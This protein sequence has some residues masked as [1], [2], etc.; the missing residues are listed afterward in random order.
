VQKYKYQLIFLFLKALMKNPKAI[1]AILPSSKRLADRI[2]SYVE[3]SSL[4]KVVELGAG[5]GVV[6]Q[7]M[8][9][10]GVPEENI[11]A[12]E[13]DQNLAEK[14][15]ERFPAIQIINADAGN[16]DI[17]LKD[18]SHPV[19]TIISGLPLRSLP[20]ITVNNIIKKVPNILSLRGKFIQFTYDIRPSSSFYPKHYKITGQEIVWRNFPPAKVEVFRF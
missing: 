18:I 20:K 12:I 1:G 4:G 2:A 17:I 3:L 9:D 13:Y 7:A 10:A 5:T 6:T 8:L 19:D 14:L 15:Q 11:I 16:L